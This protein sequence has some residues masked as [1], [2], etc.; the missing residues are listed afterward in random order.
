MQASFNCWATSLQRIFRFLPVLASY[1]GRE[2]STNQ[3]SKAPDGPDFKN[4]QLVD[5]FETGAI[6]R[7]YYCTKCPKATLFVTTL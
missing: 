7:A 4:S 5:S 6:E 3:L 2:T 1:V